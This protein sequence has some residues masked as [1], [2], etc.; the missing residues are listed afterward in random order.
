MVPARVTLGRGPGKPAGVGHWQGGETSAPSASE[1]PVHGQEAV[2]DCTCSCR[3]K[4]V[5]A[6]PHSQSRDTR[7]PPPAR[8]GD[9]HDKQEFH[10][11]LLSDLQYPGEALHDLNKG[12]HYAGLSGEYEK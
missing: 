5:P 11:R 6:C 8:D 3:T 12:P 2:H 1:K 9:L 10:A 7:R 4:K